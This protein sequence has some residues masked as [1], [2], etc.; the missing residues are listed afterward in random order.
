MRLECVTVCLEYADF[1]EW[2]IR[3]NQAHFDDWV[4]VTA[5]DDKAT[6]TVCDRYGVRVAFCPHFT[7]TG[8][9]FNKALGIN[10]GLSHLTCGDWMVHMDADCILPRHFRKHV[11]NIALN[12]E[13]I[14]GI[15]RVSCPNYEEWIRYQTQLNPYEK[16]YFIHPPG[17]WK[18]GTRMV[19]FDYGGW[20]P[21]GFFQLWHADSGITRYPTVSSANAEHTDVLHGLQWSRE[22]R[23]LLP[24]VIGIHIGSEPG[25][26]GVNWSGRRTKVFG[27]GKEN[28]ALRPRDPAFE[29]APNRLNGKPHLAGCPATKTHRCTCSSFEHGNNVGSA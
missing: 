16:G 12:T 22:N 8:S 14:Y 25:P 17:D 4:V 24:E 27:N 13:C 18:V 6:R 2:S 9:R 26:M 3:H 19:H 11:N 23:V 1:L 15:D 10:Q 29:H 5:I 7:R 20:T 28:W 21:L